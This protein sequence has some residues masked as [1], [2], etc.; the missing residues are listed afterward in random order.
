MRYTRDMF[1]E[2]R[3]DA[4]SSGLTD[5]IALEVIMQRSNSGVLE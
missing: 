4:D 5:A 3:K 2:T 1:S